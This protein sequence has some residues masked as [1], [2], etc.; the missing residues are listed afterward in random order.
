MYVRSSIIS[1]NTIASL[2]LNSKTTL[3]LGTRLTDETIKSSIAVSN[4]GTTINSNGN[5]HNT[6]ININGTLYYRFTSHFKTSFRTYVTNYISKQDLLTISGA[7]Y[8]DLL[9]HLFKRIENQTDWA[10][11]KKLNGIFG[12]GAVWEGVKS[13]RY[14]NENQRKE[15]TI[16][17]GFTQWEW[18]PYDKLI[19]VGGIRFDK[20]ATYASASSPKIS[21]LYKINQH[22]K[23]RVSV[24]QGFKAPDF[25]QLYLDFTNAAAGNYSVFGSA[26]AQKVISQLNNLGQKL[27][28]LDDLAKKEKEGFEHSGG[29]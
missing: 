17:Y 1:S 18:T 14:D 20:N 12:I 7:P 16:Q 29:C 22:Q 25:R 24:G 5:E 21:L 28:K 8:N 10:I 27:E 11:S 19:I 23:I 13:S 2:T 3:L 9:N 6:D 15:N 4:G 26:Q